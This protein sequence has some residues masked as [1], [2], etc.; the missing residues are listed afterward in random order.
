MFHLDACIT[1]DPVNFFLCLL[2]CG[3]ILQEVIEEKRE[4]TRGGFVTSNPIEQAQ[5]A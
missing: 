1:D 2:V 5:L 4:K 3:R